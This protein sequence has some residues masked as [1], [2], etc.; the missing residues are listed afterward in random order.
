MFPL[1]SP[2]LRRVVLALVIAIGLLTLAIVAMHHGTSSSMS[3]VQADVSW[4][5]A[6]QLG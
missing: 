2:Q 6:N 3:P 1:A 4:T 5:K